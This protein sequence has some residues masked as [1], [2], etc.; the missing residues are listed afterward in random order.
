MVKLRFQRLG[1]SHRPFYRLVAVDA[2]F[3]RTGRF[4]EQL[5]WHNPM[6]AEGEKNLELNEDRISYWI[7]VGAQ[8][9][10]TVTD[11][12]GQRD[13][14]SEKQKVRWERLRADAR[15]R[16]EARSAVKRAETAQASLATLDSDATADLGQFLKDIAPHVEAAKL[17]AKQAKP[18][19]ATK[20]A[21]EAEAVLAAAQKAEEEAKAKKA[22][23]D[24]EAAKAAE[25]E[26][27]ASAESAEGE[28]EEAAAE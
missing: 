26:A 20:S 16:G 17:S 25:A 15:R 18:D 1:R 24:A 21:E 4:I 8:P 28:T 7:G 12:L 27:A 14:L 22:A 5:G 19:D 10:D 23:E 13:L 3:K 2:R 9:T 6:A 11:I